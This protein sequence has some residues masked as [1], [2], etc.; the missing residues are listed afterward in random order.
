VSALR[1][2]VPGRPP[3]LVPDVDPWTTLTP[4][5]RRVAEAILARGGNRTYAALELGVAPNVVQ[6]ARREIVAKGVRLPES[7][8]RGRDLRPRKG[9]RPPCGKPMPIAGTTCARGAG[10]KA[11]CRSPQSR[12]AGLRAEAAARRARKAA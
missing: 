4:W 3:V 11:L 10:H 9:L 7:P 1:V 12:E 6:C 2:S 5:Q 8:R